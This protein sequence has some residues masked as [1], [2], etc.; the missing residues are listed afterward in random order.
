[1]LGYRSVS[2]HLLMPG[3]GLVLLG[4]VAACSPR[5]LALVELSSDGGLAPHSIDGNL[6]DTS[7]AIYSDAG[8]APS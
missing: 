6:G 1:M 8:P 4:A 5:T 3:M 7:N 2:S